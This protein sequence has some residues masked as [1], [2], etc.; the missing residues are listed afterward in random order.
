VLARF[1]CVS[2]ALVTVAVNGAQAASPHGPD[3]TVVRAWITDSAGR[4]L[5]SPDAGHAFVL[6]VLVRNTGDAPAPRFSVEFRIDG[7][8]RSELFVSGLAARE[9]LVADASEWSAASGAHE[10][11]IVLDARRQVFEADELDNEHGLPFDVVAAG[12]TFRSPQATGQVLPFHSV[13]YVLE[14]ANLRAEATS[15]H[16]QGRGGGPGWVYALEPANLHLEAHARAQATL[17]VVARP[18]GAPA[19]IVVSAFLDGAPGIARS[20]LT[21]TR[22]AP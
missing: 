15:I 18:G 4:A 2:L 6:H 11:A 8:P 10:A 13:T 3:L 1:V 21:Q 19:D 17:T 9:D 5:E 16:L 14:V 12:F 20:V 7:A 22:L